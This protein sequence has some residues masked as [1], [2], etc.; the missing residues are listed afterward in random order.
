MR[1]LF[2]MMNHSLLG[3]SSLEDVA[4]IMC[5]QLRAL[6][7]EAFWRREN[8][9]WL[10]GDPG[11]F[12]FVVEGFTPH[13]VEQMKI[14]KAHGA[15]IICLATEEPTEKGFNQGT[16]R[17]M[18][19][20]QELFAAAGPYLD[21]ILHLVPGQHVT[22]WYNQHAPAAYAELGY[23]KSLIRP[24]ADYQLRGFI[25]K[26][27]PTFDF[28]FFSS[29]SKRRLKLLKKLANRT[30]KVKAVRVVGNFPSQDERDQILLDCKVVV[31]VR[32]FEEMGLVSSSRCNTALNCGRPVIAEPHLLSKPWDE[33]VTFAKTEEE[34][35][36]MAL[37]ARGN[38]R[39]LHAGQFARFR[40]RL[41]PEVCVG[42]PLR[43]VGVLPQLQRKAA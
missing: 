1:F 13:F 35:I 25:V 26:P 27:E 24:A 5:N 6:G 8:D 37:L 33:I 19:M 32:K 42:E 2:N 34:F 40:D 14:A 16:Q 17:E 23:A 3:Q 39:G 38:W 41:P 36:N 20:R 28:G 7:H 43:R 21:A 31:Q 11:D 29:I 4:G 15:R 30:G 10:L 22:D 18:V 12:N 9:Q